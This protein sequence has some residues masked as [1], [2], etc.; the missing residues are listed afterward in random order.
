MSA[1][2]WVA[3]GWLPW[4]PEFDSKRAAVLTGM[5]AIMLAG[6]GIAT[7][8]SLRVSKGRHGSTY[9]T[10]TL[11]VSRLRLLAVRA[12]LGWLEMIAAMTVWYCGI[13]IFYPK[14]IVTAATTFESAGVVFAGASGLYSITLLLATFTD[15]Q[16][17]VWGS[18]AVF[19]SLGWLS[20]HTRF[21][22][23]ANIFRAMGDGLSRPPTAPW[24]AIAFPLELAAILFFASLIVVQWREY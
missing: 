9:F 19:A 5:I 10:L 16:W 2:G 18:M 6:A 11:P 8:L 17:R 15:E 3:L 13:W 21:A 22:A 12:A 1:L 20:N 23:S 4:T 14:A 24:T 7:Q